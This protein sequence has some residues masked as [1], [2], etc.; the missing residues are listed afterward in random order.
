MGITVLPREDE[1]PGLVPGPGSVTWQRAADVRTLIAAGYALVLQVAHPTVGA[2]VAEHS[3]YRRDPWGRLFRTLDFT[4][5]LIYT[6]PQV[7]AK[8]AR[9]LRSIHTQIKGVRADGSRYH[10][11]EPGAYAW[12]HASLFGAIASAHARFGIPLQRAQQEQFWIEWRGLGRLLG[13]RE[14]DLPVTLGGYEDYF[15]EM[16]LEVLEDNASVQGVIE[17]LDE[18][19]DL[20]MPRYA[21]P[22]WRL[23]SLPAAH[24]LRL[25]TVGMLPGILR[26]RFG[27]R[28]TH[29]QEVELRTLGWALRAATPLMPQSLRVLGPFYLRWRGDALPGSVE[30]APG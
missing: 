20:P 15:E 4:N 27:L 13:V 11:L 26:D 17:T 3:S 7:A 14:R 12:V 5:S 25:A 23:G 6:E 9:N 18:F 29:A 19:T 1:V 21:E 10:A 22:V 28:W 2:G 24:A 30:E 8:V 16:V